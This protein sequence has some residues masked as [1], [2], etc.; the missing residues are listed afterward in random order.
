[1]IGRVRDDAV[2]AMEVDPEVPCPYMFAAECAIVN[3]LT[4][5][6]CFVEDI[7]VERE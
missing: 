2:R 4:D 7:P 6:L 3:P 1:M 5:H